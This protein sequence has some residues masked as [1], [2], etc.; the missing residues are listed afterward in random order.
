LLS[1]GWGGISPH[2]AGI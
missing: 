1:S 2:G